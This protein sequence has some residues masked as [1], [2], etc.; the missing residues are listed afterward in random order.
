MNASRKR[1]LAR[2]LV[3]LGLVISVLPTGAVVAAAEVDTQPTPPPPAV[4]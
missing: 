4:S 1:S 2:G 3:L